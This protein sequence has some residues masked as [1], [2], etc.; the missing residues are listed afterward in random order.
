MWYSAGRPSGQHPFR[1]RISPITDENCRLIPGHP[2]RVT[3]YADN[4][5]LVGMQS[6]LLS[7]VDQFVGMIAE[8]NLKLN[9]AESL[10][11]SP[12]QNVLQSQ[13]G[14]NMTSFGGFTR[15]QGLGRPNWRGGV[16]LR[17]V[18]ENWIKD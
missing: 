10:L 9:P 14:Y 4:V 17:A 11:Y 3:A 1:A 15:Y 12:R 6:R 18:G 5:A 16:C 7:A 8:K 13:E 2:G